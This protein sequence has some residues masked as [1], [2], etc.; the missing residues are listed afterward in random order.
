MIN[1]SSKPRPELDIRRVYR[2]F[3]VLLGCACL[4][5]PYAPAQADPAISLPAFR[6]TWQ[7]AD[8]PVQDGTA[9]PPRSWLWGPQSYPLNTGGPSCPITTAPTACA[10][11]FTSIRPVWK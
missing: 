3:L 2:I 1:H 10:R 7:R 8:K 11:S 6:A 9:Q 5:V 4:L